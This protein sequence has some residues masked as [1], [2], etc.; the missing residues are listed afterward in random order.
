MKTFEFVVQDKEGIHARPAGI[1][2]NA[3]KGCSSKVDIENKGK[4]VDGKRLMAVMSLGVK[5]GETIVVTAEGDNEAAD[6]DAI[7]AVLKENL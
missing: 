2:V 4:K 7:M 6:A 5:S 1:L 3:I